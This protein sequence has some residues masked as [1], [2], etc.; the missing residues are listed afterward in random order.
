MNILNVLIINNDFSYSFS[1]RSTIFGPMSHLISSTHYYS[2]KEAFFGKKFAQY[3]EHTKDL[4][5]KDDETRKS[6]E[7]LL[8]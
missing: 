7:A 4:E 1:E 2:T 3:K 8:Q 6:F 5:A